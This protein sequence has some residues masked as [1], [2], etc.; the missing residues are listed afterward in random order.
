MRNGFLELRVGDDDFARVD[1]GGVDAALAE[2]GGD[3]AAG[4]ALAVADDQV[5][6]ARGQFENRGQ[7]A[8]NFVELVE[9][10]IDPVAERGGCLRGS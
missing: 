2:C 1:V 5:G 3:H 6:D 10:L 7:A 4:E 9:F 8:Q